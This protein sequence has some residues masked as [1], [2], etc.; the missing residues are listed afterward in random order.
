MS[1]QAALAT[2]LRAEA[3]GGRVA[4][5]PF[6]EPAEADAL[7]PAVRAPGVDAAAWGGFPGARRRVVTARPD[8]VP[9]ATPALVAW[10][11]AG[12]HDPVTLRAALRAAGVAADA[13]GDVVGH[14]DGSSVVALASVAAPAEVALEGVR[15]P[16]EVASVERIAAGSRK[17]LTAVV[18]SLRVDVLGARAFGVSRSW[19]AKGVAAG[20]VR[21]NGR[22]ADK[23]SEAEAGDEVWA[24][25]LGRFRVLDLHG[26]TRK[27]RARVEL[28]VERG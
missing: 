8:H 3:G 22:P 27:G 24:E 15:R 28:E 25:G 12:A 11:V 5:S 13:L 4:H 7:L 23:G 6:L 16:L 14:T 10:Y 9:A 2:S 21:L 18:P 19:F 26:T 17:R 1:D 20:H